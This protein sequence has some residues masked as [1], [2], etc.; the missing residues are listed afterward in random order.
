[1]LLNAISS[2]TGCILSI[3]RL[4]RRIWVF[5][6]GNFTRENLIILSSRLEK[7]SI[8]SAKLYFSGTSLNQN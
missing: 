3:D 2:S 4:I 7:Q 1:M 5:N 8:D 6:H